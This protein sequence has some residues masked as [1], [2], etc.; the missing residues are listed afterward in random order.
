MANLTI[1]DLAAALAAL[2]LAVGVVLL[3]V[4]E[5]PVPDILGFSLTASLTWL[6]RGALVSRS[7]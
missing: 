4:L 6:F 5:S 1:Q 3:A 2:V 7:Q